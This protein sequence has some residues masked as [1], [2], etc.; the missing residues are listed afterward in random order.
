MLPNFLE[1]DENDYEN[2][3]FNNQ[4][5]KI[6]EFNKDIESE[7]NSILDN[8]LKL[9]YEEDRRADAIQLYKD[10]TKCR[11]REALQYC[12][13][14]FMKFHP[15]KNKYIYDRKFQHYFKFMP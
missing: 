14:R 12:D 2:E 5:L 4:F 15:N 13:Q 9:M 7:K 11:I 1:L 3:N 8:I 6:N 10:K